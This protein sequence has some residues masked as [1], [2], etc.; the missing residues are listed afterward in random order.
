MNEKIFEMFG[1][2]NI[3]FLVTLIKNELM[4]YYD[5]KGVDG[6]IASAMKTATGI[7][8]KK[9]ESLPDIDNVDP[10]TIYMIDN[11]STDG[12]NRYDEYFWDAA[13]EKY[14]YL[15]T[16]V[17]DLSDYVKKEDI[18]D[19]KNSQIQT[20]WDS[21]FLSAEVEEGDQET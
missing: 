7:T 1:E 6:A 20:I 21:V 4:K 13:G 9:V 15:G 17:P 8:F 5:K 11:G 10:S 12:D 16:S 3:R 18:K 2:N 14:E 19:L